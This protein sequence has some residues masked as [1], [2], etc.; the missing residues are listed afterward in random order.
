METKSGECHGNAYL[1]APGQDDCRGVQPCFVP[2]FALEE[3]V[4]CV[5]RG[6]G[7]KGGFVLTLETVCVP[8]WV[9]LRICALVLG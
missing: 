7:G 5:V 8:V 3:G 9:P 1:K 6:G 4:S 2:G